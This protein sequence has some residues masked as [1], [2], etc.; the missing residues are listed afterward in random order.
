MLTDV[1]GD[2]RHSSADG[3][4]RGCHTPDDVLAFWFAPGNETRWFRA[5]PAFDAEI[6]RRFAGLVDAARAGQLASWAA[7]PDGSLALCVLLD[8]FPRNIWRGTPRAFACDAEARRVAADAIAAG[9]DRR[10]PTERRTF[11]YLPFEHSEDLTDQERCLALMRQLDDR[12]QLHWAERHHAV[13]T[14]FGRFPHRN[15]ILGRPSSPEESEFL[16]RPRS[17]F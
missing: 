15:A 13:I 14:R 8:Q 10:V 6:G 9:H 11:F 12:D 2:G 5:D 3:S 1:D 16:G 4:G 17:S 7:T